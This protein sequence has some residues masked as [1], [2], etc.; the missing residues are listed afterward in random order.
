MRILIGAP[1]ASGLTPGTDMALHRIVKKTFMETG[2][3]PD[4][5][6]EGRYEVAHARNRLAKK[7]M[8]EGYDYLFFIDDDVTP[9]DDV[10]LKLLEHDVDVCLGFYMH[11]TKSRLEE[12]LTNLCHLG[13]RSFLHQYTRD[14][15]R[16]LRESGENLIQ[17]HGGGLGCALIKTSVFE[18]ISWPWFRWYI[19][20]Q[21]GYG[22]LSEDLYFDV[23][24]EKVGIPIHADTRI[25]CKHQFR[26]DQE[27]D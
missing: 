10:L 8:S 17:V 3:W 13:E 9:P 16:A 7:A 27:C 2:C 14:E 18:R 5:Q 26:F 19:Y 15:L 1:V 12:S 6:I 4:L 23:K 20:G 21:D 24:C 11:R 22:I 25:H